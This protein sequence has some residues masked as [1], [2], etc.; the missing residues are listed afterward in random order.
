LTLITDPEQLDQ[1]R[2]IAW[3]EGE[4]AARK[5][6]LRIE[7]EDGDPGVRP[8]VLRV[9]NGDLTHNADGTLSL[10]TAGAG[11]GGALP[12]WLEDTVQPEEYPGTPDTVDDEFEGLGS[13]DAKWT[14]VNDPGMD[15]TTYPGHLYVPM[16]EAAGNPILYQAAPVATAV[17]TYEAKVC[18]AQTEWGGNMGEWGAVMIGIQNSTNGEQNF[19]GTELND[20]NQTSPQGILAYTAIGTGSGLK[21]LFAVSPWIWFR[22]SKVTTAAYTSSNTYKAFYSFNGLLFHQIN[23][24]ITR[25]FTSDINRIGLWFRS[26]KAQ[27]GTP[28]VD[29]LVDYF[30]RVV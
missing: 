1:F 19:I 30:R 11:G 29:V 18:L 7:E 15:Q 26:P 10:D 13:I 27:T 6:A 17:A 5:H 23:G 12:A 21:P 24:D 25:T 14:A 2:R 16:T 9:T 20:A 8:K 3:E 28:T 22:F 4:A